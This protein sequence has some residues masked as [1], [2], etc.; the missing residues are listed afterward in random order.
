[1]ATVEGARQY[2]CA[3]RVHS[4]RIAGSRMSA[5]STVCESAA[6]IFSNRR[7]IEE[8]AEIYAADWAAICSAN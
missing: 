6:C 2:K 5:E 3:L 8:N 7:I 4:A 1:M